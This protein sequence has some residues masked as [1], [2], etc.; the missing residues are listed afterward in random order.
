MNGFNI[1]SDNK[2]NG[3]QFILD[4]NYI[5]SLIASNPSKNPNTMCSR[6]IITVSYFEDVN[7]SKV[8]HVT[9]SIME[10]MNYTPT[11]EEKEK[12]CNA[13]MNKDINE[14]INILNYVKSKA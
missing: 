2:I 9:K 5:V 1:K 11:K 4:N 8:Q 3:I 6:G 10:E 14:F 13:F 12:D 7:T